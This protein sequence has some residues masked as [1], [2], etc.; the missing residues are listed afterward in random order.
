MKIFII[1][2]NQRTKDGDEKTFSTDKAFTNFDDAKDYAR[3]LLRDHTKNYDEIDF[4]TWER[5][6]YIDKVFKWEIGVNIER[7]AVRF[8]FHVTDVFMSIR[9]VEL[10]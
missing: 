10:V 4:R 6:P 7:H 5:K 9:E 3:Q 2:E 8:D 1:V